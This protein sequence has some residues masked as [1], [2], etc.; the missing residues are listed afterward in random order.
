MVRSR[1]IRFW[2]SRPISSTNEFP[3]RCRDSGDTL[4]PCIS[5][6]KTRWYSSGSGSLIPR[7]R[8][9]DPRQKKSVEFYPDSKILVIFTTVCFLLKTYDTWWFQAVQAYGSDPEISDQSEPMNVYQIRRFWW[10]SQTFS[11]SNKNEYDMYWVLALWAQSLA[12][13]IP[14]KQHQMNSDQIERFWES[15]QPLSF[16]H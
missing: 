12:S 4:K 6:T 10:S 13:E 7:L 14:D 3:T 16:S 15:S 2:D 8:L 11:F 9:W 5:R 1:W